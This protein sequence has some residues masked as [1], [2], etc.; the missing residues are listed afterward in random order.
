M[1]YKTVQTPLKIDDL[2]DLGEDTLY[3]FD[4][5]SCNLKGKDLLDYINQ[6]KLKADISFNN[7]FSKF[8]ELIETYMTY[9]RFIPI[10]SID[11]IILTCIYYLKGFKQIIKSMIPLK[12]IEA[13]ANTHKSLLYDWIAFYD[14]YLIYMI[15]FVTNTD[16]S[17]I[18]RYPDN[19][20]NNDDKVSPNVVS[21]LLNPFF[22]DYYKTKIDP[23]NVYY[24]KNYYEQS[25]DG[26]T[27]ESIMKNPNNFIFRLLNDMKDNR[28]E[29]FIKKMTS[30][31]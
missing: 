22:Y 3:I 21:M 17:L 5:D 12:Y 1:L 27:F 28:F 10:I 11:Y 9:P 6:L 18:Q 25:F 4:Y 2:N 7:N 14:S 8:E 24:W 23:N 31:S 16:K 13:F 30:E 15:T 26:Q 20:I 19:R 29:A